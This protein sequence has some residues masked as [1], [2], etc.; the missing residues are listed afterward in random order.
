M[1]PQCPP[2]S[3]FAD[4]IKGILLTQQINVWVHWT[5]PCIKVVKIPGSNVNETTVVLRFVSLT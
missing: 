2:E 3:T 5:P 1:P 4:V